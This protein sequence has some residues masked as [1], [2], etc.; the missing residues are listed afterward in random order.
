MNPK[1]GRDSVESILLSQTVRTQRA[2]SHRGPGRMLAA[3][4]SSAVAGSKMGSTES[5]PTGRSWSH[6]PLQKSVEAAQAN[7]SVN[8]KPASNRCGFW[9]V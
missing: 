1:V 7:R 3:F 2:S 6:W 4:A 5:R 9:F 8:K